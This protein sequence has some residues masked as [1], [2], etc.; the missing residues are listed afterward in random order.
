MPSINP[1]ITFKGNC[2]EAFNFYKSAFDLNFYQLQR[3]KEA[4]ADQKFSDADSNKIMHISL[5]IGQHSYLMGCDQPE[6]MGSLNP[7][8]NFAVSLNL[9]SRT[10]A[11]R[12]FGRLSEGG[13]VTMPMQ[14][15]FWGAYFGMF[16]DKFGI[17]WMIGFNES[18]NL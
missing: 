17:N 7:G 1:Y 11:D 2:E 16:T 9:D 8:N 15:T 12:L 14:S 6:S 13:N 4:P 18:Q 5:H 10:E 3:Y